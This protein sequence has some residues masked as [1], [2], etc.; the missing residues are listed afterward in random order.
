M[1]A[2]GVQCSARM[3]SRT[4]LDISSLREKILFKKKKKSLSH[5]PL[6]VVVC[7]SLSCVVDGRTHGGGGGGFVASSLA[8]RSTRATAAQAGLFILFKTLLFY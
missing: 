1:G 4:R 3:S 6:G 5:P 8:L 7:L 2:G